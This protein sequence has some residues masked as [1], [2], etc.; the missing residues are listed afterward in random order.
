MGFVDVSMDPEEMIAYGYTE[1]E[2]DKS[3]NN[4]ASLLM[5]SLKHQG[6]LIDSVSG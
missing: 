5:E 6:W 1:S 3:G 2:G 4:V